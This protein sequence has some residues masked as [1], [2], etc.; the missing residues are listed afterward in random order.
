MNA[1]QKQFLAFMMER[2]EE[3]KATEV[4]GILHETFAAQKGAPLS[5]KE[6]EVLK[7]R[8]TKLM[9]PQN[10]PEVNRAMD[11]YGRDLD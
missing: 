2:A 4:Q 6:F 10:V 9:K 1:G 5:R 7:D 11:H 8:L 3:E